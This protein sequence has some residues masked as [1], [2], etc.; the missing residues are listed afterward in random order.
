[1]V[2]LYVGDHDPSGCDMRENDIPN[3]LER[4]G[5]G[6]HE[7]DFR[8]IALTMEQI[9]EHDLPSI[10]AKP[11]DPRHDVYVKAHG[12]KC[13]EL[14]ALDPRTLRDILKRKVEALIDWDSWNEAKEVERDWKR[15]FEAHLRRWAGIQDPLF[16]EIQDAIRW[17]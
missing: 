8:V 11:K 12:S 9:I 16:D 5:N 14:D 4:Y 3:R 7:V 10:P 17:S 2:A 15:G 6:G 13:W 1:M